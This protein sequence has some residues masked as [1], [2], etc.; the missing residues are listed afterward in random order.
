MFHRI[1]RVVKLP[2]PRQTVL[3][4]P[5]ASL[6]GTESSALLSPAGLPVYTGLVR[7]SDHRDR[8]SDLDSA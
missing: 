3:V 4:L 6:A 7:A 2:V 1:V 8:A 5:Q